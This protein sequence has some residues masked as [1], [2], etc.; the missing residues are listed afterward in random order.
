MLTRRALL[1]GILALAAAGFLPRLEAKRT[2]RGHAFSYDWLKGRAKELS[3]RPYQPAIEALPDWLAHIDW[4]GYQSIRFRPERALWRK[5]NLPFQVRLFHLGLFF[6]H[7]VHLYEVAAGKAQLIP[8]RA[9]W[10]QFGPK[11]QVPKKV[12]DL[13][14][15]GFRVHAQPDFERDVFAFLGA[16]YFRA[17]GKSMQYGM[18]ARGLAIN[19]GL[20]EEFPEFREFYLER[21]EPGATAL[22][23]YAL[24]D[25]PSVSGAYRFAVTPGEPTAM[26]IE[27]NLYPRKTI[28]R[29]GIAPLTSMFLCGENDRRVA[30]DFRPEIHDSD[31]LVMWTGKGEWIWRPLL[32]PPAVRI[33]SFLDHNPKGFGL[34]QRDRNFDHYQDD[35]AN[36][37]LRPSTWVEPL[38]SWGEGA[39]QLVEL[40]APDETFDNV[41]AFW[42][43]KEPLTPGRAYRFHYRLSW[44][45][46]PEPLSYGGRVVATRTGVG[47]IP[48]RKNQ[49]P[50]RKFVIDFGGG[51][52]D[53]LPETAK[54]EPV[55]TVSRGRVLEPAARPIRGTPYWRCNFDLAVEGQEPVD[56]RC[57]LRD[58][59]GVLTETWLYQYLPPQN[60]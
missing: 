5:A 12:P 58:E 25:G 8:Y 36:Y 39:V 29:V 45:E 57:F 51:R 54:V 47:G 2:E 28:E 34:L 26:D 18:S 4:D 14:Y 46:A 30:D 9:D 6:K 44:G 3:Q 41:V 38:E 20:D 56:M 33:N 40:P 1:K 11:I 16:S 13:G 15:A 60:A 32:N 27:A 49:I 50:S 17:V 10:F 55:I 23:F 7:P 24:L 35:G 21:P 48:G 52:L 43:P 19:T 22:I 59:R 37:H 53:S 42:H 31:G